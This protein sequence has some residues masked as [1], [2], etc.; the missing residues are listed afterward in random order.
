MGGW[1]T[2]CGLADR[3]LLRRMGPQGGRV[4]D[5]ESV[6][7]FFIHTS[8]I[9]I[10]IKLL[11]PPSNPAPIHTLYLKELGLVVVEVDLKLLLL[12]VSYIG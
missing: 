8:I 12:T 7:V 5:G 1:R 2:V 4:L 3:Q 10:S 6:S 11:S 9:T